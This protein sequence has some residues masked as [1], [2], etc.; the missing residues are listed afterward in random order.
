MPIR[1]TVARAFLSTWPIRT[2]VVNWDQ[3]IGLDVIVRAGPP[4]SG[5][6][7]YVRI[8]SDSSTLVEFR[9]KSEVHKTF[10]GMPNWEAVYG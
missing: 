6:S 5:S 2:T 9:G 4:E 10:Q 1:M 8:W 3:R 7:L